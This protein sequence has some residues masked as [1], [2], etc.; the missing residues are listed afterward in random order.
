MVKAMMVLK[1]MLNL[2]SVMN[3]REHFR[4]V[5][6]HGAYREEGINLSVFI[7]L[8]SFPSTKHHIVTCTHAQNWSRTKT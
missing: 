3:R 7:I 2:S 1:G 8:Y 5:G 4:D 6:P